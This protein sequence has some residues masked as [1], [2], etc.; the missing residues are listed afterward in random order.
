MT[1]LGEAA[2]GLVALGL[3]AVAMNLR[4]GM[5]AANEATSYAVSAVLGAHEDQEAS[6]LC[7]QKVLEQLL[8]LV[9]LD[10]EGAQF[11]VVGGLEHRADFDADGIR[12]VLA[13]HILDRR[14]ERGGVAQGLAD[15]R[16]RGC[17]AGDGRLEAHVEHAIYFVEHQDFYA[18]E[19]DELALEIVLQAPGSGDD[20]AR[21]AADGIEL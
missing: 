9:R 6:L 5:S 20:E 18:V 15:G 21:A 16:Q 7:T 2:Q 4:G 8:L 10:F 11:N 17:D 13:R 3:R 19:T 12:E 1:A 14:F